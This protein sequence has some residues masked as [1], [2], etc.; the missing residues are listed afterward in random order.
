[1]AKKNLFVSFLILFLLN[2]YSVVCLATDSDLNPFSNEIQKANISEPKI[3][4]E[5]KVVKIL[6]KTSQQTYYMISA[7]NAYGV[8][9]NSGKLILPCQYSNIVSN[10]GFIAEKTDEN[11]K[12]IYGFFALNGESIVPVKYDGVKLNFAERI[13]VTKDGKTGVFSMQGFEIMPMTKCDEFHF[14]A[15]NRFLYK[16]DNKYYLYNL[17]TAKSKKLPC[18][19]VKLY[20][21]KLILEKNAKLGVYDYNAEE[22]IIPVKYEEIKFFSKN[23]IVSLDSKYGLLSDDG[24]EIFKPQYK[25]INYLNYGGNNLLIFEQESGKSNLAFVRTDGFVHFIDLDMDEISDKKL[26]QKSDNDIIIPCKINGRYGIISL[27]SNNYE[28]KI[29]SPCEYDLIDDYKNCCISTKPWTYKKYYR[30][31]KNGKYGLIDAETMN[32]ITDFVYDEI[33]PLYNEKLKVQN[34]GKYALYNIKNNK[35][36]NFKYDD[37]RVGKFE[38]EWTGKNIQVKKNGRWHYTNKPKIIGTC[39]GYATYYTLCIAVAPVTVPVTAVMMLALFYSLAGQP[40]KIPNTIH[41]IE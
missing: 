10:N 9:T 24:K 2:F 13:T 16:N 36:G 28:R 30:A 18:E 3:Y 7:D 26:W 6:A 4:K 40:Y 33:E 14:L 29:V 12:K 23:Y 35:V 22:L 15:S 37:I 34:D 41:V 39:A 19:K 8:A 17:D 32:E 5:Y 1:M 20:L 21:P 25:S 27:N 11:G 31:L 38:T